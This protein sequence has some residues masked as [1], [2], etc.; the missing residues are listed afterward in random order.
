VKKL[1]EEL[2]KGVPARKVDLSEEELNAI[3]TLTLLTFKPV[4]YCFNVSESE[5]SESAQKSVIEK[6]K[7]F[8]DF[9]VISAKIESELSVMAPEDQ[10]M[11]MSEYGLKE[12]GLDRVIKKGFETLGLQTYLTAGPKEVRAWTIKKGFKAPQAAGVIHSDFERGFIAAEVVSF[13]DL[14]SLG[15]YIKAKEQGKMRLEG[16]EYVMKDGDVVEFRFNV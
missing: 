11:F 4:I 8:G 13:E 7:E 5:V 2:N 10:D 12:S 14:T 6:F 1:K 3:K 9:V 16:K 15:S